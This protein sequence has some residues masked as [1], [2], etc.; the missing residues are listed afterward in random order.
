M[1]TKGHLQDRVLDEGRPHNHVPALVD[2]D[3]MPRAFVEPQE[4]RRACHGVLV[5]DD[6]PAVRH[7]LYIHDMLLYGRSGR[8]NT[9]CP[10]KRLGASADKL[11]AEP[12]KVL[13][14]VKITRS[15]N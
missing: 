15:N 6:V 8:S 14:L 2:D 10:A 13:H 4:F 3:H 1:L 9:C 5:V 7:H 12:A 11:P